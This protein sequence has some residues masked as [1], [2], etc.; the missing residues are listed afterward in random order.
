MGMENYSNLKEMTP[1]EKW[2]N[3]TIA[4]NFIF[5]KVMRSHPEVCK[6]LLEILLEFEIEKLEFTQ[7]EE[8]DIDFGSKGIRMDVLAKNSTQ[9]FN[10]EMQ[11]L[12]TK[13]LPERAR[14]YQGVVDVDALKSGQKY[15]SLKTSYIIFICIDDIFEKGLPLYRFENLC[16][17][18][19]DLKMNDRA[20]KYFFIAGNCDKLLNEKQK[21]FLNLVI[22]NESSNDF[23]KKI[24][25]LVSEAKHNTA[26]RKKYM[27]LEREKAYAFD[28][29][30]NDGALDRA[31]KD[32]T[33]FLKM[34]VCTPEQI[35]QAVSLPLEKVLEIS[36]ELEQNYADSNK[37]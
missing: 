35:A 18:N 12:N 25:K 26:W 20:Y 33:N 27:D 31:I 9:L 32:A 3:A 30:F 19:K 1:E 17:E 36:K 37:S 28:D 5:Y 4:N 21:A 14:Y 8:I 11:T 15:K 23:S 13:E 16:L 24:E 2:E 29:G 10:I 34:K 7:Q 6:E 22:K